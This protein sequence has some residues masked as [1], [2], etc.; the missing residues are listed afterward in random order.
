MARSPQLQR[1]QRTPCLMCRTAAAPAWCPAAAAPTAGPASARTRW[2]H[3][4]ASSRSPA[5]LHPSRKCFA[6]TCSAPYVSAS[7]S[8]SQHV[9]QSQP[10]QSSSDHM[11]QH[12]CRHLN[13]QV[14]LSQPRVLVMIM[15]A[16]KWYRLARVPT[17]VDPKSWKSMTMPSSSV[18]R[19]CADRH[20]AAARSEGSGPPLP[21]WQDTRTHTTHDTRHTHA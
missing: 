6:Y 2:L 8:A 15:M 4:A 5:Q 19:D 1:Q 20:P 13:T 17:P 7:V 12:P 16:R 18:T 3:T 9:G 10:A 11:Y 21:L 14:N